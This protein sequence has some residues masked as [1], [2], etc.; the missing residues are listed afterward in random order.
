[1]VITGGVNVYPAEVEAVLEAHPD[2]FE[3]AVIGVPDDVW[4]EGVHAVVVA[5]PGCS[6][7]ADDIITFCRDRMAHFKAPRSVE[8]VDELPHSGS[9]KVLK[10]DLKERYRSGGGA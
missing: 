7:M 8:F 10:R 6:P 5:R 2:V 9:G 4:G 1:M 3:S